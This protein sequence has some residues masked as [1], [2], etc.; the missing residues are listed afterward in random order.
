[1]ESLFRRDPAFL[2]WAVGNQFLIDHPRNTRNL[3]VRELAFRTSQTLANCFADGNR[4]LIAPPILKHHVESWRNLQQSPI[5]PETLAGW[6]LVNCETAKDSEIPD[7]WHPVLGALEEL[8]LS[9][10]DDGCVPLDYGE[11]QLNLSALARQT[12]R[13]QMLED[14]YSTSLEEQ[15]NQAM[16]EL[17]YGLSHEINNPLAN[18]STRA[19]TLLRDETSPDRI[20]FL[21]AIVSQAMRSFELIADMMYFANPPKPNRARVDVASLT[22]TIVGEFREQWTKLGIT[23]N[24]QLA[25]SVDGEID[26]EQVADAIRSLLRNSTEA[27]TSHGR[28]DILLRIRGELIELRIADNGRGLSQR[29]RRH[30]FDPYFCG[31]EAGRGLGLGLCK[32]KRVANL[33]LGDVSLRSGPAGTIAVLWIRHSHDDDCE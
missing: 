28:I 32:V 12:L 8:E 9:R 3:S 6:L 15:K 24:L 30:A 11:N 1:M 16:K 10:G 18:I 23:T 27:I 2:I 31:R 21:N 25:D 7:G 20:R 5:T 29:E 26:C 33:H 22:R 14:A 13:L 17:A 19:Q 4:L